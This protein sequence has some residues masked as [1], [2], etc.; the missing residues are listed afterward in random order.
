MILKIRRNRGG[1]PD[2]KPLKQLKIVMR[3][4]FGSEEA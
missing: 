2:L 4:F 1:F 3:L